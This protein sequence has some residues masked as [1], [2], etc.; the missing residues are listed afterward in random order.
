MQ[1]GVISRERD[2]GGSQLSDKA[3]GNLLR[4]WGEHLHGQ[5]HDSGICLLRYPH[6]FLHG[7]ST[8]CAPSFHASHGESGERTTCQ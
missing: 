2:R 3:P 8:K 1:N 4:F 7:R 6:W 5:K